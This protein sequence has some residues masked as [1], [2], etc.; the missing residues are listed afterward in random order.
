M[1]RSDGRVGT[2]IAT[3]TIE[4]GKF[5]FKVKPESDL[6]RLN[7]YVASNDFPS[8]SREIFATPKSYIQVNGNGNHI[9]TWPVKSEVKEQKE[10]DEYLSAAKELWEEFQKVS[11]EVSACWG[12]VDS[13]TASSDEKKSAK[14]KIKSLHQQSE[15]IQLGISKKEIALMKTKPVSM[16]WM[17]KLYGL[18]MGVRY[19]PTYPFKEEA[20]A[21]Y[22]RMTDAEKNTEMGKV[23]GSN[24]FPPVTVKVGDDMADGDLYD[25]EGNLHHLSEL[26]GKYMLLDFWSSGCG[27]CIM[28]IPEMGELQQKYADKLTVVSLSSDAEK[29]WRA[30]SARHKMT[31]KN[32]SDKKQTAGLYMK[33]GVR[34]IPH[35]VLISPEGK[36]VDSWSGYGK[37]SLLRKLRPY[38]HPKPAMSM[39]KKEG[40]LLVNYP[41]YQA[42]NTNGVLEI[43]Q[44]ECTPNAT[45]LRFKA[46]Y[47]PNNWIRIAK[48]AFLLTP[49]GKQYKVLKAE[50][51]TLGKEFFMPESGEAEFSLTFEPLPKATQVFTFQEGNGENVWS[52]MGIKLVK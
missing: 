5:Y 7:L 39:E 46:Y 24:L 17:D 43:K 9:F 42:N 48:E 30:A 50:G 19:S 13:S 27:P 2:T 12:I 29:T 26:K 52:V 10:Y 36:V 41:D 14:D 51:I 20:L 25:L 31:W 23:I 16:I 1:F 32:W 49:D 8:M 35:Y 11:A 28:A 15:E 18:S 22:Q 47:T 33:Y 34:G 45:V 37:G 6:D 44:V 3:D 21:L 4:G 38:M 40:A